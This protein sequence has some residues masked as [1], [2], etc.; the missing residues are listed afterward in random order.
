[1]EV[2][3]YKDINEVFKICSLALRNLDIRIE[4]I[5]RKEGY[6][7]GSTKGGLLS[8][9]ENIELN[10]KTINSNKTLVEI[11]SEAKA[12]IIAWGKNNKNIQDIYN[13][14]KTIS[15]SS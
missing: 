3:I 8:W 5:N 1:M 14:I 11:Y 4:E 15:K 2:V 6:I 9:G 12:Q 10:I 13:A 7:L